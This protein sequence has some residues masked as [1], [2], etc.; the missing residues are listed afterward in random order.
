MNNRIIVEVQHFHGC[1]NGPTMIQ[2][3]K[4]AISGL[5]NEIEYREIIVDDNELAQKL[6]FLGS[7]TLLINGKDFEN[8]EFGG[9]AMLN[10]RLYPNGIPDAKKIREKIEQL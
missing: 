5:E 7:P 6:K 8:R 4:E 2:N 9:I 3:V 10:C 1:P